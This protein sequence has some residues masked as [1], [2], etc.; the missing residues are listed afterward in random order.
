MGQFIVEA[1]NKDGIVH[2]PYDEVRRRRPRSG[3][4]VRWPAG[5]INPTYYGIGRSS[6]SD[7]PKAPPLG[8]IYEVGT[9]FV[10]EG[11]VHVC[12]SSGSAFL[13]YDGSVDISGGPF[14]VVKLEHLVATFETH[15]GRYWN[16]GNNGAGADRGV[17]FHIARPIFDYTPPICLQQTGF[18]THTPTDPTPVPS[19]CKADVT[20]GTRRED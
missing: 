11:E 8:R 17:D 15:V 19:Y 2:S 6:D 10:H 1:I 13:R 4:F 12:E 5:L 20:P 18:T 3:D 14:R 16:W 7:L 9:G